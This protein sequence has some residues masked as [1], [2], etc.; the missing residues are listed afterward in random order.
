MWSRHERAFA[1]SLIPWPPRFNRQQGRKRKKQNVK[2]IS[3]KQKTLETLNTKK[4][5]VMYYVGMYWVLLQVTQDK[6]IFILAIPT[7]Y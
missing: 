7:Y 4:T 1:R 5:P 2:E 3:A 6:C